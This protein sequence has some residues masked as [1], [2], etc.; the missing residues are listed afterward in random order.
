MKRILIAVCGLT[1]QVITETLYA[2][3]QQG[4]MPDAIRLLTTRQGKAACNAHL[5]SPVD[6]A[7][8]RL[9]DDYGIAGDQIDF[10]S[11]HILTPVDELGR[12]PDDIAGEEESEQFLQ[13]CMEQVFEATRTDDSQ[14]FFSIA[15]G[16]KTMGACLTLATH[17]YGRPQDRLFHV[18]VSSEFE[19]NR[20]FFFP[21]AESTEITLRDSNGQPYRKETRF[22][23]ISLVSIPFF[24]IRERLTERHLKHPETPSSLM[25]SLVRE[26]RPELTVDLPGRKLIWKGVECDLMPARLALYAFF[27]LLKKDAACRDTACKGC[28]ACFVPVSGIFEREGMIADLYRRIEPGKDHDAMSDTGIR[29][30][31]AENFNAY[32]SKLRRDLERAFGPLEA[33]QLEIITRGR[34]PHTRYGLKLEREQLRIVL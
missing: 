16:R 23:K 6:G 28:D 3:H 14:V 11:R 12:E 8:Y 10:S 24:S 34:R 30:I 19:S 13:L 26:K 5:V 7:Y 27:A 4:R 1:P 15:G 21:P 31:S 17:C 22:A 33:D 32:K 25:L 20:D 9:L 29:A 2:L 18:L